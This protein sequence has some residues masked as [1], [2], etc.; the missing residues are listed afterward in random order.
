MTMRTP[1]ALMACEGLSL[2]YEGRPVLTGVDFHVHA[3]DYL[4]VVGEN[5]SGKT[6]LMK[7]ILGLIPPLAGS[8]T[9]AHGLRREEIGYLPQQTPAQR[10][11]PASVREVVQSGC[12][13]RSGRRPFFT[14][15]QQQ[16]AMD[17]M[18]RLGIEGLAQA[19]YRTLS[20]GQQQR[21][22]LARALCAAHAMLLLDE[23]ATGLDPAIT[24]EMYQ[25]IH[26]LN[27]EGMTIMMISHDMRSAIRYAT[28]ILHVAGKPL[29]FGTAQDYLRSD[30]G[31][32]YALKEAL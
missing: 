27:R 16:Q 20:G 3:G 30:P 29:F 25:L 23:P 4:C 5:G 13:N 15:R 19:S 1:Q 9:M 12:L 11:F 2:G 7:A 24:G 22:L 14:R 8:I 18:A 17:N 32:L 28:H 6:T 10:D 31:R 26:A 21:V